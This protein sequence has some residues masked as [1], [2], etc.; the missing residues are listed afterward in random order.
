MCPG[1]GWTGA[2][3]QEY[4]RIAVVEPARPE[5]RIRGYSL[6]RQ[7][8]R[9]TGQICP[10]REVEPVDD[11]SYLHKVINGVRVVIAPAEIDITSADQLRAALLFAA[12]SGYPML[13]VDMSQTQFCDSSGLHA[14]IAAH[15]RARSERR[16]LRLVTS[17]DG[18]VPRI[19][20]VMGIDRCI[21][22][23]TSLEEALAETPDGA[24]P[25]RFHVD[26]A[27]TK[28]RS[29]TDLLRAEA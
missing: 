6:P 8:H 14:L 4:Y 23:F 5:S 9:L 3:T 20:T 13:V 11:I 18:A 17:A 24:D 25:R 26:Q 27:R 10:V 28:L 21:P 7:S 22:C 2:V 19:F 15:R 16:E 1:G 12:G 29:H